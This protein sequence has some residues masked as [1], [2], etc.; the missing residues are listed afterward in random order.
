MAANHQVESGLRPLKTNDVLRLLWST[1]LGEDID[2]IQDSDSFFDLGGDSVLSA[3]LVSLAEQRNIGLRVQDVFRFPTLEDMAATATMKTEEDESRDLK[4][5]SLFGLDES[6]MTFD[7][8]EI[9]ND[10]ASKCSIKPDDIEDIYPSTPLQEGMMAASRL[11]GSGY[12]TQLVYEIG[13]QVDLERFRQA[14]SIVLERNPVLRTRIVQDGRLGSLQCVLSHVGE[15]KRANSLSVYLENDN[16]FPMREGDELI[17]LALVLDTNEKGVQHFVLTIHHA[18]FDAASFVMVLSDV[19]EVYN[20]GVT[21][22][23]PHFSRYVKYIHGEDTKSAENYWVQ[24]LQN[25]NPSQFPR[26]PDN[27]GPTMASETYTEYFELS[28]TTPV[29]LT[30]ASLIRAAWGILM[31]LH[32]HNPD[33]IFALTQNGRSTPV[34]EINEIPGPTISVLPMRL[35]LNYNESIKKFLLHVQQQTTEMIPFEYYG[36]LNIRRNLGKDGLR[37]CDYQNLLLVQS[38]TNEKFERSLDKLGLQSKNPGKPLIYDFPLVNECT[39]FKDG[40]RLELRFDTRVLP[41]SW[42]RVLVAQFDSILRELCTGDLEAPLSSIRA[43]TK[44]DNAQILSWNRSVVIPAEETAHCMFMNQAMATPLAEAVCAWDGTLTFAQLDAY[45]T[46]MANHLLSLGVGCEELVTICLEKSKWAVVAILSVLKAGAAWIPLDPKHPRNRLLEV[47]EMSKAR[48]MLTSVGVAP[49]ISTLCERVIVPEKYLSGLDLTQKTKLEQSNMNGHNTAYVLF[50][51]GSTGKPKGVVISHI[52]LCNAIREQAKPLF[53]DSSWR[54]LQ[55]SAHTF[56]PSISETLMTLCHGGCVCIPSEDQRLNDLTGVI[57]DLRVNCVQLTPSM[58]HT[59]L[60][61]DIPSVKTMI[62]VGEA[63]SSDN[64]ARWAPHVRLMNAYGPT[65]TCIYCS[66]NSDLSENTSPLDIGNA[67]GGNN[68][69]VDIDDH[70]RLAAVGCVG[71]IVV[72]GYSLGKGYLGDQEATAAAFVTCS[73]LR[74]MSPKI[75]SDRIYRTGDLGYYNPDGSMHLIGRRD[76]QIKLRGNRIELGEIENRILNMLQDSTMLA[77]VPKRGPCKEHIVAIISFTDVSLPSGKETEL[78][79]VPEFPTKKVQSLLDNIRQRLTDEVP[80]YMVPDYWL[81]IERFPLNS[82]GKLD[83]KIVNEWMNSMSESIYRSVASNNEVGAEELYNP[84]Y[85][86][87]SDVAT[88]IRDSWAKVL[89]VDPQSLRSDTSFFF[90][91][92]DSLSAI[93]VV[94][95]CRNRGVK[96]S[97]QDIFRRRSLGSL[98]HFV[99][100]TSGS[101]QNPSKKIDPKAS[102]VLSPFQKSWLLSQGNPE[103]ASHDVQSYVLNLNLD[104][105]QKVLRSAF[106]QLVQN[107]PMLRARFSQSFN[108]Q[109]VEVLEN[110]YRLRFSQYG[111]LNDKDCARILQ[112]AHQSINLVDGPVFSVDIYRTNEGSCILLV[113]HTMIADSTSWKAIISE[114]SNGIASRASISPPAVRYQA[115]ID[116]N[117]PSLI[118]HRYSGLID[119]VSAAYWG[120]KSTEEVSETSC[121]SWTLDLKHTEQIL[122]SSNNVF[123]T[124]PVDLLLAA[125]IHSFTHVFPDKTK[126]EVDVEYDARQGKPDGL[127]YFGV[128]GQFTRFNRISIVNEPEAQRKSAVKHIKKILQRALGADDQVSNTAYEKKAPE[129]YFLYDLLD[130]EENRI[131]SSFGSKRLRRRLKNDR[132]LRGLFEVSVHLQD[133]LLEF[134]IRHNARIRNQRSIQRWTE[135]IKQFLV[136]LADDSSNESPVFDDPAEFPLLSMSKSDLLELHTE[137]SQRLGKPASLLIEDMYQCSPMQEEMMASQASDPVNFSLKHAIQLRVG[138]ACSDIKRLSEAWDVVVQRHSIL[139]TFFHH[140]LGS[141][142][143]IQVVLRSLKAPI[144][145]V[146]SWYAAFST[147]I[148]GLSMAIPPHQVSI[149]RNSAKSVI[150]VLKISHAIIDGWSLSLLKRD[151]LDE[152]LGRLRHDRPVISYRAFVEH[153]LTIST[154]KDADYWTQIVASSEPC[155]L[156]SKSDSYQVEEPLI[157]SLEVPAVSKAVYTKFCQD[158]GVTLASIV[159][160]AWA[161]TLHTF[162]G[163]RTPLFGYLILGRDVG[164][165]GIS[166]MMGMTL[167]MLVN[168]TTIEGE[169]ISSLNTEVISDLSKKLQENRLNGMAHSQCNISQLRRSLCPA[170][171]RL[172]NTAV[173]LQLTHWLDN[174]KDD[175]E[176]DVTLQSIQVE[177]PWNVDIMVA[178]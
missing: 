59:I 87:T 43:F 55:F 35:K 101:S 45:S 128:V 156:E 116:A 37:A 24:V 91:G 169:S 118:T 122:G 79:L 86:E 62:F 136:E 159:D 50:T 77:T 133:G 114:L 20:R 61:E 58:A 132:R 151:L 38:D 82:S 72:S 46:S 5:M 49:Q 131:D 100:T 67:C 32:S 27:F 160:T 173:N 57:R 65:E 99:E 6:T 125:V 142:R 63:A 23:R 93:K 34:K 10:L 127:E 15:W 139:R 88:L 165:P 98:C 12:V 16:Y 111:R 33:V 3:E 126:L 154:Q 39:Y 76:N 119:D 129:I 147:D 64:V 146:P 115:W 109:K 92:G 48:I 102:F 84:S 121:T 78:R 42:V 113:G 60:P 123:R 7:I 141:K 148:S 150:F 85:Y 83:R 70:E 75:K 19:A 28:W 80:Q 9:K 161:L 140:P 164:V 112:E 36:S 175:T 14:W 2:D 53:C 4:S 8:N 137:L 56:D 149:Y 134:S 170:S 163:T 22:N 143:P 178:K 97:I 157:F 71:E 18:I 52:A 89:Q 95:E 162:T 130:F 73:W 13:L 108:S 66:I 135:A 44:E 54:S 1:V 11:G 158:H 167:N 155:L 168:Q 176:N 68:W 103:D 145:V 17:R 138:E 172:F 152:Y 117:I 105:P 124:E 74:D 153:A 26:I 25:A 166:E 96:F 171:P 21:P 104:V 120:L 40:Y 51:S 94:S 106:D 29:G 30:K 81:V 107:H 69:I 110:S 31:G 174:Q 41:K 47:I 90:L 177:D 144:E